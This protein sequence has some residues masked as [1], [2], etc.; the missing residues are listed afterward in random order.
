MP[1]RKK[2]T[3]KKTQTRRVRKTA[4]RGILLALSVALLV[5]LFIIAGMVAAFFLWDNSIPAAHAAGQGTLNIQV[6]PPMAVPVTVNGSQTI[7]NPNGTA[8]LPVTEG[9]QTVIFGA[10]PRFGLISPAPPTGRQAFVGAG[11][12]QT[13][14]G[15]Y[16]QPADLK[17]IHK[18]EAEILEYD[19][20]KAIKGSPIPKWGLLKGVASVSVDTAAVT[21]G[22]AKTPHWQYAA[23]EILFI[24]AEDY[25]VDLSK[26]DGKAFTFP[27]TTDDYDISFNAVSGPPTVYRA[28]ITDV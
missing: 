10:A 4:T 1:K 13:I 18:S 16:F 9:I 3:R 2:H 25:I 20:T 28:T 7:T 5:I 15:K 24:G 12:S 27:G 6:M 11:L 22:I 8:V 23:A 21:E 14:L 17:P 26:T 19:A